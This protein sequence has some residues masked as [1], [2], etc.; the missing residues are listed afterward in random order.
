M[1]GTPTDELAELGAMLR[2]R[3]D[4]SAAL[5]RAVTVLERLGDGRY[6]PSALRH[7]L[8]FIYVPLWRGDGAVL[9]LHLWPAGPRPAPTTSPYHDHTWDLTSLVLYGRIE[10]HLVE[11]DE[12]GPD[13]AYRMF[14]IHGA[15]A[16]DDIRDTGR[17]IR[18]RIRQIQRVGAGETY[19]MPAGLFH[20]TYVPDGRQAATLVLAERRLRAPEHTIGDVVT[21]SHS[22]TRR[23]CPGEDVAACAAAILRAMREP[24]RGRGASGESSDSGRST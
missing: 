24:G 2:R 10:N 21:V 5:S 20:A 1:P 13:A 15:G 12:A 19:T 14:E 22:V 18:H 7:P 23:S 17:L 3:T 16:Q 4:P 8:G 6:R 9:R 11:I